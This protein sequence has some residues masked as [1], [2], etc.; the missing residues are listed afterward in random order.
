MPKP[1]VTQKSPFVIQG[2]KKEVSFQI[3]SP[4]YIEEFLFVG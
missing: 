2:E 4:G 1:N 3:D